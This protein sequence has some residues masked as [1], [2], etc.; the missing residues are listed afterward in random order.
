MSNKQDNGEWHFNLEYSRK[1]ETQVTG[2]TALAQ[3]SNTNRQQFTNRNS[4]TT[5]NTAR[6]ITAHYLTKRI[7]LQREIPKTFALQRRSQSINTL[8]H[9]VI[10][11]RSFH[12]VPDRT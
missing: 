11:T 12:S 6:H 9:S 2:K 4:N 8:L 7:K 3:I 1:H 5:F 10:R